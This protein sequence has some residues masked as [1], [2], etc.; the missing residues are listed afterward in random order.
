VAGLGTISIEKSEAI[1]ELLKKSGI[2]HQVSEMQ[3][4]RAR[5]APVVAQ[6]GRRKGAVTVATKTSG[7]RGTDILF[8]S[9][10]SRANDSR[11]LLKNTNW[12]CRIRGAAV[13]VRGILRWKRRLQPWAVV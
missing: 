4:A 1:R 9:R 10:Q 7:R 3:A 2:P 8:F 13:I 12:L 5:I 6:A 11:P